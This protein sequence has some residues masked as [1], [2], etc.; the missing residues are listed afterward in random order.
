MA[1]RTLIRFALWGTACYAIAMVATMPASV[2]LKNRPWRTGIAGTVWNGEVGIAGG[3]RVAW[4]WAPLRSLANLGFAAD[5]RASGTDT[6]LGGRALLFPGGW[7]IDQVSGT[8]RFGLI[9]A[10]AP[11]LPF[12]CDMVM[13]I[14]WDRL[15]TGGS[16]GASGLIVTEPG[17]CWASATPGAATAV[18]ALRITAERVGDQSL[19]RVVP[20][21]Q[22]RRTLIEA[23]LAETG[24]MA[25]TV[26][27]DGAADL[28]FLGVPAGVTIQKQL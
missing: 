26:T 8:A 21:A 5:W 1:R 15:S 16:A 27:P 25:I 4:Q 2:V 13:R 9:A 20:Q 23:R 11:S 17:Q 14:D 6:D 10:A 22:Q 19:I 3:S 28:P 18:P 24:S 7:R 12:Q